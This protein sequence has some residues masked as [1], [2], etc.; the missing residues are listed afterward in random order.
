MKLDN[1]KINKMKSVQKTMQTELVPPTFVA[2][3]F[4]IVRGL[5]ERHVD[6]S[7][8]YLRGW[9]RGGHWSIYLDQYDKY[10]CRIYLKDNSVAF[11]DTTT[12]RVGERIPIYSPEDVRNHKD[13]LLESL[14]IRL[15]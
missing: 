13:K 15:K 10:V 12:G 5:L 6:V 9:D 2:D 4:N 7:R 1:L 14:K 8:L 11:V 3:I